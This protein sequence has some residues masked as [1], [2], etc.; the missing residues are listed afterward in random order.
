MAI[1]QTHRNGCCLYANSPQQ[2]TETSQNDT[3]RGIFDF[4]SPY[5]SKIPKEIQAEIYEAEGRTP[6]AKDRTTRVILYTSLGVICVLFAFFNGFLTELRN[7]PNPDGVIV[8][9]AD[10]GFGWVSENAISSF[11]FMNKLGGGLCLLIGGGS[12]LLAEAEF[13]TRRITAEKIYEEMVRRRS[14][15]DSKPQQATQTKKKKRR[16]KK[17]EALAEVLATKD[18][19]LG[20]QIEKDVSPPVPT[21]AAPQQ[22]SEN[23]FD[24][25]KDMYKKA[26][27]MAASQALLLNK[28]LED[29]GILEKI[30]DESGLKVV[31]KDAARKK[32]D[33]SDKM[34]DTSETKKG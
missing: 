18:E 25:M 2:D 34:S 4:F 11:L 23:I 26:D 24:K 33:T 13:D 21:E 15:R 28:K 32:A 19:T 9:L 10:L 20:A 6:A 17:L 16:N 8:P 22:K 31:G 27:T 3:G 30:T 7:T 1:P 29:E 12:A 5:E 14:E